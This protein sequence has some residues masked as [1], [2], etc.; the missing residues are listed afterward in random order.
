[1]DLDE[2]E[3]SRLRDELARRKRCQKLGVCDYC[4][5]LPRTSDCKFPERHRAALQRAVDKANKK[6]RRARA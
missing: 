1:M 5:R 2:Y 4:E 6:V 3:E